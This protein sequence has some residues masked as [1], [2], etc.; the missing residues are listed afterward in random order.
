MWGTI[1]SS[2][3]HVAHLHSQLT[4]RKVDLMDAAALKE[5]CAEMQPDYIFHL[6]AQ[7]FV[8][9]SWED[10]WA[11]LE[12]NIRAQ[13]N[14]LEAAVR[15]DPMPRVLVIG[16]ADEYGLVHPGEL[17]IRETNPLRPSSPYAV[18]KVA[19]DLLGYQY[20]VS[21]KLPAIRVRPFNHLGPRQSDAFVASSFARQIAEAEL[22]QREPV[23]RVGNLSAKRDFS[24]VRD[25]VRGYYLAI[26][27]G[28]PGEV[29]NLGSERSHSI[30]ELL[31][32]L[33]SLS[34]VAVRIEQDPA[35]MRPSEVPE[36]LSDCSK[37]RALTGWQTQIPFERTLADVLDDWRT[38][39]RRQHNQ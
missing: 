39:V 8:P 31:T 23:V 5:F 1:R 10:P 3:G 7:S 11:T 9:K 4:L 27:M 33:Q 6:A 20:A 24:D 29:Y 35:R 22:G 30:Q 16:S 15:L 12:N 13:L 28:E 36:L 25:I 18:S 17:P 32:I 26:T 34:T 37:F 21:Y 14:I 19:Q 38:K 2:G